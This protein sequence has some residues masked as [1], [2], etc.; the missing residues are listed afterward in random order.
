[1]GACGPFRRLQRAFDVVGDPRR[2]LLI[3]I[4]VRYVMQSVPDIETETALI[5]AA[6]ADPTRFTELYHSHVSAIHALAWARLADRAAAE[7]ITAETFRR[8]LRALPRFE[9]RG[10]S[11]RAWL[12]RIC[13]NLVNDEHRRRQRASRLVVAA[14]AEPFPDLA[15]DEIATADNRA[16]VYGL[17]NQLTPD[18]RTVITLRFGEDLSIAEAATRLGRSTDAVKQLQ[19]RAIAEL[20]ALLA[21]GDDDV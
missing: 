19:R 8:A 13:I 5:I 15:A 11:F 4:A 10:V 2:H 21:E 16:F 6:Q 20:R 9:P 12:A 14:S 1:M 7:D 18:H 17:V 3:G